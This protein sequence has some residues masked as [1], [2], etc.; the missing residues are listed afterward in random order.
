MTTPFDSRAVQVRKILESR[1]FRDTEVLKRLF[2]YLAQQAMKEQGGDLKEYT[3]G[4]EAFGK[5][6]DY[7]P[8]IDSSVRVQ[9]GKLRQRLDA[10]YRTEGTE[11]ELIVELPKG[12]FNLEF[13]SRVATVSPE[14]TVVVPEPKKRVSWLWIPVAGVLLLSIVV[15]SAFFMTRSPR[16]V[17]QTAWTPEMQEFWGPF[18]AGPRP[19]MVAVG[20]PMFLKIGNSFFRDPSLNTWEAASKSNQ[21]HDVERITGATS[22]S[23]AYNY[24]GIGEAEGAFEL[25][26][27]LL[28]RGHDLTLQAS[29]NLTWEDIGRYNMIFLGPPKFNPQTLDLPIPQDFEILHGQVQNLHPAPG[30]PQVFVEK[31]SADRTN[32]EEGHALISRLPG[33]HQTGEMLVLAG[34]STESSRAAVEF[35]TR[36]EY[37]AILVRQMRE[38]GGV[39]KWFQLVVHVRFKS[40]TPIAM[41]VVA[42]HALK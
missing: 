7:N 9:A 38:R 4:L 41:D 13:R 28:T 21:V 3:V 39:P 20:T 16:S 24:T 8:Q 33:L 23:T 25:Q 36:P 11:D 35:V 22:V 34:S 14:A 10:Y 37:V 17:Q 29:S 15:A 27:L 19:I 18:L 32:L 26:R 5:S 2:D 42:I 31:W 40:K 12:H 30:E 6:A 1:T